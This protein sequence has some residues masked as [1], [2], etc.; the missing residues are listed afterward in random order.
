MSGKKITRTNNISVEIDGIEYHGTQVIE[1][2]R[3]L[4]QYVER[5]GHIKHDSYAYTSDQAG[6]MQII[7][8]SLLSEL[9]RGL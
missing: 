5:N 9:V 8:R 1:G 4:Y 3:K 7:A 2:T 6:Y